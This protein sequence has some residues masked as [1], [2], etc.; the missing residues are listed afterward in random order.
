MSSRLFTY[1]VIMPI[2]MA[3]SIIIIN[4]EDELGKKDISEIFFHNYLKSS[5]FSKE[6]ANYRNK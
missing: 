5:P 4:V 3:Y 6:D 2:I 1:L